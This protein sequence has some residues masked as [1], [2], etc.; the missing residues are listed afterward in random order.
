MADSII[1]EL[2]DAPAGLLNAAEP[3]VTLSELSTTLS[4]IRTALSTVVGLVRS[5]ATFFSHSF[6]QEGKDY[7][8]Q[9]K[10]AYKKG[11]KQLYI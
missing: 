5:P 3:D 4:L 8:I 1:S 11:G 6:W 10:S 9:K 7:Q 2:T